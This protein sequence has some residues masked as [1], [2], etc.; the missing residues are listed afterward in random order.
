MKTTIDILGHRSWAPAAAGP[1]L[2][3]AA[4]LLCS[5]P[6]AASSRSFFTDS[7]DTYT[8]GSPAMGMR[9]V[10]KL[11]GGATCT[12]TASLQIPALPD[13]ATIAT[14]YTTAPLSA[15]RSVRIRG[16]EIYLDISAN[17]AGPMTIELGYGPNTGSFTP[18][19]AVTA[20]V[21][22]ALPIM[23]G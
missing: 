23:N 16:T 22:N 19:G 21:S 12:T 17:A 10:L 1:L 18:L 3:V 11:S 13:T 15:T 20:Q 6:A 9:G 8:C 7:G 4:G 5:T 2:L 14:F